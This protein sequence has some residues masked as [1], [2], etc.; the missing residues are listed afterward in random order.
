MTKDGSSLAAYTF[1][2][3]MPSLALV[4]IVWKLWGAGL[5]GRGGGT[6][7]AS[8]SKSI[9]KSMLIPEIGMRWSEEKGW[10][11][12]RDGGRGD[13]VWEEE[14][15][16]DKGVE[17]TV[18][19]NVGT[20]GIKGV[21]GEVGTVFGV[22]VWEKGRLRILEWELSFIKKNIPRYDDFP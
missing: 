5:G 22:V 3:K 13:S 9:S 17:G 11:I 6:V 2:L 18:F 10:G 15:N 16:D 4:D 19:G 7:I 14:S 1:G 8:C 21:I 12:I 20:Q